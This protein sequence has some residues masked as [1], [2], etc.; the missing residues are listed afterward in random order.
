MTTANK[1]S[2]LKGAGIIAGIAA[3]AIGTF[4]A[5]AWY[6][7][8]APADASEE[9]LALDDAAVEVVVVEPEVAA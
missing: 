5:I 7:G 2:I 3:L 8:D 1:T 9:P 4:A 6:V